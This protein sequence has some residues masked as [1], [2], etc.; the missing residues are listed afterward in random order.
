M[1]GLGTP[2]DTS[3]NCINVFFAHLV[4][5]RVD[6]GSFTKRGLACPPGARLSRACPSLS[7]QGRLQR[8]MR[9]RLGT[10]G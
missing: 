10:G 6:V 5:A 9:S 7:G 2:L 8:L 1:F 3:L 4:V